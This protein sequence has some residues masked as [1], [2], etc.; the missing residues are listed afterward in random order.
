MLTAR[1]DFVLGL[2]RSREEVTIQRL[3]SELQ[4]TAFR[5]ITKITLL[6]DVHALQKAGFIEQIGRARATRYRAVYQNPLLKVFDVDR[7][8]QS[9]DRGV[10]KFNFEIF[11]DLGDIFSANEIS[12]LKSINK[13]F[14]ENYG[15]LS[16]MV[17]Q[18]EFER[19]TVELSWKSSR[20]EGN[21]YSLLDTE[22]LLR[23]KKQ[24]PGHSQQEATMIINHKTAM[25][26][27]L[28]NPDLFREVTVAK[29]EELHRIIVTGLSVSTGL[30]KIPVG[31]IGTDY[32][33]LDNHYQIRE[34]LEKTCETVNS[35]EFPLLKALILVAMISYIQPFE[36]GNKRT[37]RLM[38]NAV[39]ITNN[40]CP[41]SYKTVDEVEYKKAIILFYEQNSIEYFKR[42]FVSQFEQ[43]VQKYFG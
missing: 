19:V 7:Y 31:I 33:P 25:D 24:A 43:A 20:I 1:Q 30:R 9:E 12:D 38:G 13:K 10:S 27:I 17:I 42:L 4:A 26:F 35:V 36:D 8:F 34:A 5:G 41:L 39:L 3:L 21:T 40:Y 2:L 29:I 15:K 14:R 28:Q 23:E 22:R 32:K 18:K 16:P 6:R 11:R 37:S